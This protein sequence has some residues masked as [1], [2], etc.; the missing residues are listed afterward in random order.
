MAAVDVGNFVK[1]NFPIR[2][3][4][5]YHEAPA[6]EHTVTGPLCTPND[7]IGKRV[8]LL[9]VEAGALLGVQ[10]SGA[11]GPTASPGLF[12]SHGHP[13]EVL[14]HDGRTRLV[15]ERDTPEGLLAKQRVLAY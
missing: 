9:P 4:T 5:R 8:A 14:V 10:H 15:R 1:R 2:S 7:V 11:Y 12:L 3:P 6:A 13:A